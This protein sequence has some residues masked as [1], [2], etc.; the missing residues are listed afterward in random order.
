M[1]LSF[2]VYTG[3][4]L[5]LSFL[6]WH[7]SQRENRLIKC[8]GK[9]LPFYSWEIVASILL[10]AV[11]AGARYKT[12]YDYI[13]YLSQYI[14]LRDFD[15]FSRHDYEVGFVIISKAF[16]L[17]KAH[18]FFYFAF[19][20]GLQIGLFYYAFRKNKSLIPWLALI[21]MLGGSFVGWMNTIRQVVAECAFVALVPMCTTW[22][23][24]IVACAVSLLFTT[25]HATAI[26][27]AFYL[28]IMFAVR[29]VNVPRRYCLA[30]FAIFVALGI[31]PFWFKWIGTEL[32]S[33]FE[34]LNYKYVQII[35]RLLNGGFRICSWGPGHIMLILSQV[36]VLWYYP[37][38][39]EDNKEDHVLKYYYFLAFGGMC[40][41]NLFINTKNDFLR[42]IEYLTI[43]IVV[44]L[45]Y[46]MRT[47][48]RKKYY[49]GLTILGLCVF[50]T[51]YIAVF[52]AVYTPTTVNVP[53]LYNILFLR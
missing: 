11:V 47:L 14:Q 46:T 12:G 29:N 53:F 42:P 40:L 39:K 41:S 8:E 6:G 48:Y 1:L 51:I 38:V 16:A 24:T 18:E 26:L 30:I 22:R 31:Y 33:L 4:A 27:M 35:E 45:A 9:E 52:K 43:C 20:G 28:L 15:G 36:L 13:D 10:F 7:I 5:I 37:I 25:I 17:I 32:I 49:V 23:K 34:I 50:S 21:V 44:M 19:W 3:L 2:A